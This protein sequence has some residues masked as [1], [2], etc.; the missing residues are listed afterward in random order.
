MTNPGDIVR[1]RA[2]RGGR[3]SI[4]EANGWCQGFTDGLLDGNGVIPNTVADLNVLV[5]GT[6]GRRLGE[7]SGRVSHC[8]RPRRPASDYA[9]D[10][11]IQFAH[12]QYCCVYG[13]LVARNQPK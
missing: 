12:F 8:T 3:A 13:R 6:P 10:A 9:H 1:V 4:Y 2:R 11:C 5:G 7:E